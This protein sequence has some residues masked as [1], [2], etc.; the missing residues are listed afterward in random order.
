MLQ[1]RSSAGKR[2]NKNKTAGSTPEGNKSGAFR[3]FRS[4]VCNFTISL[5]PRQRRRVSA[6]SHS[7]RA[8]AERSPTVS[9]CSRQTEAAAN[10]TTGQERLN[11]TDS[12][13]GLERFSARFRHSADA[14]FVH[15]G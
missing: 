1:R 12:F 4:L 7:L 2:S 10:R 3:G 8:V 9:L 15:E 11:S 6:D 5:T 13:A 14:V